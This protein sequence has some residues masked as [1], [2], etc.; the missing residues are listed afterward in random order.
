MRCLGVAVIAVIPGIVW[1]GSIARAEPSPAP[2]AMPVPQSPKRFYLEIGGAFGVGIGIY[3]AGVGEIGYRPGGG[4]LS[5]H[6]VIQSGSVVLYGPIDESV[7]SSGYFALRAGVEERGCDRRG[8]WCVFVSTDVGYLHQHAKAKSEHSDESVAILVP[9]VGLDA[10][11]SVVR[12]RV[13]L[14]TSIS[15]HNWE[16][17]GLAGGIAFNW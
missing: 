10:G 16:T 4:S 13:G 11:G 1:V 12:V 7:T 2:A 3:V 17:L 6:A 8:I 5:L 9:R 14:E 15:R